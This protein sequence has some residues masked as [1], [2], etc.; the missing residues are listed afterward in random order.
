MIPDDEF[1]VVIREWNA[2]SAE[3]RGAIAKEAKRLRILARAMPPFDCKWLEKHRLEAHLI[4]KMFEEDDK[5]VAPAIEVHILSKVISCPKIKAWEAA[6]QVIKSGLDNPHI[7]EDIDTRKLFQKLLT[8]LNENFPGSRI[9]PKHPEYGGINFLIENYL[10]TS[11]ITKRIISQ[12]G[13]L[14]GSKPHTNHARA[15]LEIPYLWEALKS[16]GKSK[17][18]AAPT[19]AQRLGL[20][21]STVRKKLQG[22]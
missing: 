10:I 17:T 5:G 18:E 8:G 2:A 12:A 4:A 13:R 7:S 9:D 19:I 22:M 16:E 21:V 6:F 14:N 1:D 3:K 15:D 11:P 20:A